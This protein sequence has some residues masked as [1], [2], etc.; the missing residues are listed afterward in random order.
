M[1]N[2]DRCLV[3]KEVFDEWPEAC[4]RSIPRLYSDHNPILLSLLELN[5]GPKPFWFFNSWLEIPECEKV[6]NKAL[7][8]FVFKGPPDVKLMRKFKWIRKHLK[9]WRDEMV[10]KEG[11][12]VEL[13]KKELQELDGIMENY[14]LTEEQEWTR[15][16]NKKKLNEILD[17]KT[18]DLKQ[19]SR[20]KWATEG[21][22]NSRFFHG[23]VNQ[24][25]CSNSIHGLQIGGSWVSKPKE[26]KNHIHNFF[27]D[28][29]C[30]ARKERPMLVCS[31]QNVL[32]EREAE[33]LVSVFT[34]QEIKTAVF[35]C[36]D[37]RAPGPDGFTFKFLN[38]FGIDLNLTSMKPSEFSTSMEG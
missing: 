28:K 15:M 4:F 33:E 31:V 20:S 5:F 8:T 30:E 21:D 23:L 26:V 27:R 25:K 35:D 24:R 29:F 16:E 2:I 9:E 36:G 38:S 19:R 7:G 11:E 32:P 1:S 3:S 22:E 6:V 13:C 34:R 14:E 17:C 10:S 18:K 37:D 12:E